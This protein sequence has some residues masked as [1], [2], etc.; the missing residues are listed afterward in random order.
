M[1]E[2]IIK[3]LKQ[4]KIK[5]YEIFYS[6]NDS[7]SID[8]D[9]TNFNKKEHDYETGYGLRILK[10]NRIGFVFFSDKKHIKSSIQTAIQISK[11]RPALKGFNFYNINPK[12]RVK[13][14]DK[15]ILNLTENEMK[16]TIQNMLN[17]IKTT[18]ISCMLIKN[19]SD[20]N[21]INSEGLECSQ[22]E[23]SLIAHA[24]CSNQG[25]TGSDYYES[26]KYD[27]NS[28]LKTASSASI[29][30][31]QKSKTIP[32]C[33]LPVILQNDALIELID[34]LILTQMTGE[35]KYYKSSY[36]I[37][38]E[39]KIIA[40]DLLTLY[41]DPFS[42]A[43]S[44]TNFDGEG[45]EDDISVLINKGKF[46]GFVYDKETGALDKSLKFGFCSRSNYKSRPKIGFSN[47]HIKPGKDKNLEELNKNYIVID[48]LFGFHTA[49]PTTG[50]FS[51]TIGGGYIFKNN[52]KQYIQGNILSG[53][54]Y[55]LLKNIQNIESSVKMRGSYVLPRILIKELTIS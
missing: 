44:K 34:N 11:I 53:N 28:I 39:N 9:K 16:E 17:K 51:L 55:S 27:I 50:D 35:K 38:K 40:S 8:T 6:K 2:D 25:Q 33:K 15:K 12:M 29:K 7:T 36:L 13:T 24:Y 30:S 1:I 32:S 49:N 42:E 54:I 45:I 52:K 5:D 26:Y 37:G 22:K 41:E 21:I 18:P 20:I 31:N 43:Y 23:T 4:N 47:I 3:E 19:I 46:T 10:N 14:Y 48:E